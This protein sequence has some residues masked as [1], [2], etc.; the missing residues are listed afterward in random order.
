MY[1]LPVYLEAQSQAQT[2]LERRRPFF[3]MY[4]CNARAS[5]Q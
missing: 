5:G 1:G 3:L 4:I 2:V